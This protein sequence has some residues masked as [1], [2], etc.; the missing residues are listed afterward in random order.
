MG[1]VLVTLLAACTLLLAG[2]HLLGAQ[3]APGDRLRVQHTTSCCGLT[4]TTGRLVA[5]TPNELLLNVRRGVTDTLPRDGIR[6]VERAVPGDSHV[7]LGTG[8]G[9][10]AGALAGFAYGTAHPNCSGEGPCPGYVVGVIAALP[11]ALAGAVIGNLVGSRFRRE[12]W[13]PVDLPLRVGIG[14]DST[15]P[16]CRDLRPLGRSCGR[17]YSFSDWAERRAFMSEPPARSVGRIPITQ[18][19]T[20]T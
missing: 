3:L 20:S 2:S 18:E 16:N 10:A 7:Y 5:L 11:G 12:T 8:I 15:V 13:E 14:G 19:R 1:Q 9:L 4:T 6:R 17:A